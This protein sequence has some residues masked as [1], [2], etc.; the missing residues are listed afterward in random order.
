MT[1]KFKDDKNLE[2]IFPPSI[3]EISIPDIVKKAD[4]AGGTY[5]HELLEDT[6]VYGKLQKKGKRYE[7]SFFGSFG[8]HAK[9][10]AYFHSSEN[11]CFKKIFSGKIPLLKFGIGEVAHSEESFDSIFNRESKI[12]K[13]KKA[14]QSDMYWNGNNG[15]EK[16]P[17]PDYELITKVTKLAKR[18]VKRYMLGKPINIPGMY[19]KEDIKLSDIDNNVI[20]VK[21]QPK[22]V[23]D[24]ETITRIKQRVDQYG[25]SKVQPTIVFLNF[26]RPGKHLIVNGHTTLKAL[27]KSKDVE[28]NDVLFIEPR[29]Y[30]SMNLDDAKLMGN[31]CNSDDE[32]NLDVG[33]K[34]TTHDLRKKFVDTYI[35]YGWTGDI[36][37]YVK[38][39]NDIK[40]FFKNLGSYEKK[41]ALGEAVN[42]IADIKRKKKNA[43]SQKPDY[44]LNEEQP[45]VNDY[46][47][48]L[49]QR[50]PKNKHLFIKIS[51]KAMNGVYNQLSKC[52]QN[53][54]EGKR[55]T[56]GINKL[57]SGKVSKDN[58]YKWSYELDPELDIKNID[59]I[60]FI[61]DYRQCE[62]SKQEFH[63]GKWNVKKQCI[64]GPGDWTGF[65][66]N[67]LTLGFLKSLIDVQNKIDDNTKFVQMKVLK[68]T[69]IHCEP[70]ELYRDDTK[71]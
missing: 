32:E 67:A 48:G 45:F 13:R 40:S 42:E 10:G 55:Y 60:V 57:K 53:A 49:Y 56:L 22:E 43:N 62:K 58:P 38:E 59:G 63:H 20:F 51:V 35:N 66:N 1:I 19:I 3:A 68:N 7:G 14:T 24:N 2:T 9:G 16:Y 52:L 25:T 4:H 37:A 11:R 71:A 30:Q 39:I 21:N 69:D 70:L 18:A 64:V 28:T 8:Y 47:E 12:L 61:P 44:E 54:I 36:R 46:I 33:A 31:G 26:F 50:Y 27:L 23:T 34:S 15:F 65:L 5:Y 17:T 6:I 41:K 29:I